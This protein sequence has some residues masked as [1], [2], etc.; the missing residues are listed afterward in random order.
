MLI[1]EWGL[2]ASWTVCR[3]LNTRYVLNAWTGKD[4]LDQGEEGGCGVE[5]GVG[6]GG[7]GG[8]RW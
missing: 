2:G 6:G 1:A 7:G 3:V 8:R 5:G 4:E